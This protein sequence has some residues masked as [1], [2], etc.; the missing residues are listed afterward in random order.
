MIDTLGDFAVKIPLFT[1]R[2]GF[3]KYYLA[4]IKCL[5]EK[6]TVFI[7][8]DAENQEFPPYRIENCTTA[9]VLIQ[10]KVIFFE[11]LLTFICL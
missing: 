2:G 1:D 11:T 8:F 10:Q 4:R 3:G 9:T 5:L 7:V 6:A